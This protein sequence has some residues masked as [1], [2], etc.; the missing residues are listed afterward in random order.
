MFFGSIHQLSKCVDCKVTLRGMEL[1]VVNVY[2]YLGVK[3]DSRLSFAEHIS[4][5]QSKTIP[6]IRV[7]GGIRPLLDKET[8]LM[9]YKTLVLPLFDYGISYLT[10]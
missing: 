10:P 8:A 2:K 5:V 6:K 4:Y 3:L 9:L 1:E 7:L